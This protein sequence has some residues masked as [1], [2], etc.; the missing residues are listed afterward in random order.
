M[1]CAVVGVTE[2]VGIGVR[3]GVIDAVRVLLP[4]AVTV[5]VYVGVLVAVL[6]PVGVTVTVCVGELVGVWVAQLQQPLSG[7]PCCA[8]QA[9]PEAHTGFWMQAPQ[10]LAKQPARIVGHG[11]HSSLQ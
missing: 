11:R 8:T 6:L 5:G 10:A 4:V 2:R 3:V 1:G 9:S 7:C